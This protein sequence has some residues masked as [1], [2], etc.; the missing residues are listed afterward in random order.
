MHFLHFGFTIIIYPTWFI[1]YFGARIS[2][3][4]YLPLYSFFWNW[5]YSLFLLVFF[6]SGDSTTFYAY[7]DILLL[8]TK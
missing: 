4:L 1:A 6:F 3:K 7:I 2:A 5:I 8:D